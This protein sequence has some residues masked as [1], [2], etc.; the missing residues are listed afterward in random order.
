MAI[1]LVAVMKEAF[2]G[3]EQPDRVDKAFG[4]VNA[5][6][7][8]TE[9]TEVI[10]GASDLFVQVLGDRGVHA[11]SAIG[12]AHCNAGLQWKL[13]LSLNNANRIAFDSQLSSAREPIWR[14]KRR[15]CPQPSPNDAGIRD[16]G[17]GILYD[18]PDSPSALAK[19][20]PS[21]RK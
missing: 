7:V 10:D 15:A 3:F 18:C 9:H 8:F 20:C 4:V 21:F 13:K 1:H 2:R 6:P 12:R 11:R 14:P 19:W 17:F 16:Q 5:V